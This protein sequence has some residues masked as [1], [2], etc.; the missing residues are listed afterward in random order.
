M[1]TDSEAE[2]KGEPVGE[3]ASQPKNK[4]KEIFILSELKKR[5]L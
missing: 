2:G 3:N 4:Q 1:G 5:N